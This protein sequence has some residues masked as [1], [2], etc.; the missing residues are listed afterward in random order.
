MQI[1]KFSPK[2]LGHET[3]AHYYFR[4]ND[5]GDNEEKKELANG[6]PSAGIPLANF[7]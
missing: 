7:K 5:N 3:R 4:V 1:K 2:E 6:I